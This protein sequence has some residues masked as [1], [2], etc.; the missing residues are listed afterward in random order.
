M[1][2]TDTAQD[3]IAHGRPEFPLVAG[4]GHRVVRNIGVLTGSQLITWGLT[5]LWT[6]FVP[7]LLG[8][9]GMGLLVIALA[10][11]GLLSAAGGLGLR[12]FLVKEIAA[13]PP[14]AA[15]L[16]GTAVVVRA[17]YVVPCVAVS[18]AF[19]R[20]AHFTGEKAFVLYLAAAIASLLL[21]VDLPQAVFQ[22]IER[23]EYLAYSEVLN[24]FVITCG[25]IALVLAGFGATS[26]VTLLLVAAAVVLILNATWSRRYV[27]ID[28]HVDMGR[29]T[30]LVRDSLPYWGYAVFLTI[31]Q[32]IDSAMLAVMAPVHVVG[33]YGVSTRLFGTLLVVPVILYTAWLPRLVSAFTFSPENLRRVAR[34][35][36]EAVTILSL[37][38]GIGAAV[39]A[40]PMITLIYG[41]AYAGSIPVFAILALTVV[42]MYMNITMYNLL[43]ASNRQV[44]WTR[45]LA[46]ACVINPILNLFLIRLFQHNFQNGAVGAAVS[47]LVTELLMV[48]FG[49]T[50]I[51]GLLQ[52]E[53]LAKLGRAVL[54]TAGMAAVAAVAAR[55]G[56]LAELAAGIVTF[57]ALALI[58]RLVDAGR[59]LGSLG[60]AHWITRHTPLRLERTDRVRRWPAGA[61]GGLSAM[62]TLTLVTDQGRP[63]RARLLQLEAADEHPRELLF[64][65]RLRSD[66]VDGRYLRALPL[67]RRI[68]YRLFPMGLGQVLEAYANRRRYD[69]VISWGE[70][71]SLLLAF[72]LKV[73]GSRTPHVALMYCMAAPKKGL[74]FKAVH[75]H[76]DHV[77][78]WSSVQRDI[79]IN[80][81]QIPAAKFTWIPY[82][83][84]HH[85]WRPMVSPTDMI[86]AVGDEMRDYPTLVEAMRGLEIRAHVAAR[87]RRSR[88]RGGLAAN[89]TVGPKSYTELRALYA[90]SRFVVVPV[91]PTDTDNG[92]R[93]ILEGMAMGKAVICSRVR[94]QVDVIQEGITG[95]FVPPG[96]P[97]AL[98]AAIQYL[99]DHPEVAER[100]GTAGRRRIEERHTID[101]FVERVRQIVEEVIAARRG[102]K[103]AAATGS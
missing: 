14:R 2:Q 81:L 42:P 92:V 9:S 94:G 18:V 19:V 85:F 97:A 55:W 54:A 100:M 91:R 98:R 33:W 99:W 1:Q 37:P 7:R 26:L 39:I 101:Q 103:A 61:D 59:L 35:A 47:L 96:D 76:I 3:P 87:D 56:L 25:G 53:S 6:L 84:D 66:L 95:I 68:L 27:T 69:A 63:Q 88:P 58:L 41:P 5:A 48:I 90:R 11:S 29:L 93:A 49:L 60:L 72:M 57:G 71:L 79:A 12:T 24:K 13:D 77:V 15:R 23:M 80:Q 16:L 83:V 65:D 62:R 31:Y 50:Q 70:P 52:P 34:P 10:A 4:V 64:E 78:T 32:W 74:V 46:A 36:I 102:Q 28:W 30:S 82:G 43:I 40:G 20:L 38:V 17:A 86:C 89:V 44:V 45:A 67:G 51:H 21:F 8:P 75:S 73:T 22:A